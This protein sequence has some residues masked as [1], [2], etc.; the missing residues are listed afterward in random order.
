MRY[1]HISR[2]P[3][4]SLLILTLG[5]QFVSACSKPDLHFGRSGQYNEARFELLRRINGNLD[6]AIANFAAIANDDPTYRDTLTLLG[7][8]FYKKGRFKDAH[9][10]LQRAVAIR[11]DDEIAWLLF[12]ATQ[13]RLGD[14]ERGLESVRGGLTLF[15]KAT[16]D[17][18]YRDYDEWDPA[19]RV[20]N[21][22]RRAVFIALKGLEQKEDLIRSLD[23][24]LV[25]VEDEEFHQL[26]EKPL[27]RR[28][29][30]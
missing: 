11:Q 6:K 1:L 4:V 22:T 10:I 23:A 21:A 18:K 27:N 26:F 12:G 24:V 15:N 7:R 29:Y 5:W 25:A 13:L 2:S 9:V 8:A 14:N 20:R 3:V 30:S 28:Q 16:A 17:H 19:D